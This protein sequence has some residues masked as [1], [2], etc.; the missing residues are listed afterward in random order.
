MLVADLTDQQRIDIITVLDMVR[1]RSEG[2]HEAVL[3]ASPR[4]RSVRLTQERDHS[5]GGPALRRGEAVVN[6][7]PRPTDGAVLR[8][9]H[10]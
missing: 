5:L 10:R 9:G 6:A 2:N 1:E 3:T 7:G 4:A 8:K